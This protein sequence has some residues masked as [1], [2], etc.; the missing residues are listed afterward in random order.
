MGF[1]VRPLTRTLLVA[2]ALLCPLALGAGAGWAQD[3]A[4]QGNAE[5]TVADKVDADKLALAGQVV[6]LAVAPGLDGRIAR[7][8]DQTVETLPADK[9]D[10]TREGLVKTIAPMRADLVSVFASY[11]A[12]SF[13]TDELK[14]IVAF[15]SGPV[16]RKLVAVEERKP[17][18]VTT[19]IQQRIMKIVVLLRAVVAQG[20]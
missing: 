14:A 9:K 16:G 18:E 13:T 8:I 2:T 11:Y 5:K 19:A 15:Y 10:A 7:M 4:G 6:E 3:A 12:G 20:H 17:A 1:D